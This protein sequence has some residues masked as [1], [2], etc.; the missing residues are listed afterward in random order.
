MA[1]N[2]HGHHCNSSVLHCTLCSIVTSAHL[3]QLRDG[4]HHMGVVVAALE[5][6]S[7]LLLAGWPGCH[8]DG[9]CPQPAAGAA[10]LHAQQA[11]RASPWL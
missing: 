2:P 4:R 10:L 6:F 3:E 11:V 7:P 1:N 8:T 9:F 5:R